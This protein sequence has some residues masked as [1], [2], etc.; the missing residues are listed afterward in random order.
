MDLKVMVMDSLVVL[1]VYCCISQLLL[2]QF[3]SNG[4]GNGQFSSPHGVAIDD[5]GHTLVLTYK[6]GD[7]CVYALSPDGKQ[8]KLISGLNNPYGI[9]VVLDKDGCIYVTDYGNHRIMKH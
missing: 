3:G 6:G 4:N 9:V 8:V 7:S 5:D 2:G 1:R